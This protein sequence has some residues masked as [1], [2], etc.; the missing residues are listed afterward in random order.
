ML[1]P[2]IQGQKTP[3]QDNLA[4]VQH[5][6]DSQQADNQEKITSSYAGLQKSILESG[7]A[8]LLPRQSAGA[9]GVTNPRSPLQAGVDA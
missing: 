1:D 3:F 2:D 7:N 6:F 4:I 8:A 9:E 5:K